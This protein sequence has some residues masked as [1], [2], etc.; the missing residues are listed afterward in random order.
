MAQRNLNHLP[1]I[2][3]VTSGINKYDPVHKSLYE[4]YFTLPTAIQA[5]F[6][7]EEALLTQQ[8]TSVQG[9]DALQRTSSAGEQKFYGV[10]VS[11][12][13]PILD[14][15]TAADL[16]ITFNLNLRNVTDNFVLKVFKA[17]ENLSYDLSDG[18]RTIKQDY[19]SENM[20]IAEANRDGSVWRAYIFH[21]LMLT[22]VSG[23]DDLDYSSNDPRILTCNF[24]SDYWDDDMA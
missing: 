17:W 5:E 1:H 8:V 9:L 16:T 24:R 4:V 22:G 21:H 18:T 14:N 20:R 23:L 12:L 13:N 19:I 2:K 6:K 11:F 7:T 3:N 15:G 10:T